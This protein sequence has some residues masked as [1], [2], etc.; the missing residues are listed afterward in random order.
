MPI[1]LRAKLEQELRRMQAL[2]IITP[3]S[4]PTDWV[5]SIV[6]V[7]K[8]N[9]SLRVCLD[10][11]NL[12]K[13]IKRHHHRL[14]TTDEILSRMAGAK[15]FT[16]LDASNA[17]WQ[18]QLDDESSRLLTFN[19]HIG[20]FRFLR[21]PYGI[22]SAS[23][24]CQA[25]IADIISG[26][27][28]TANAQDD[29]IIW[30][31]SKAQLRQRTHNCLQAIRESGLKLRKDKCQ[32]MQ[33]EMTFLGHTISAH[34]IEPDFNKI[35]AI[36]EMPN[37]TNVK[38]L[39]R[40]LGMIT[41][42]GK[43]IP[44]LSDETTPLRTLLEKDII[45]H[46][47]T[48]QTQAVA[49]LKSLITAS[50]VLKYFDPR[51]N[52]RI[53]SDASKKGLGAV[54]EQQHDNLWHPIAFASR[55]LSPAEQNYCPLERETLSIVFACEK[56]HEYV[57]GQHFDVFN[58]HQP[59]KSIF[60]KP[61]GKAPA[62]LQR[63]LLRLQRYDFTMHYQQGKDAYITDALSRAALPDNTPEIPDKELSAFVHSVIN[64]IP[65]SDSRLKQ[66]QIE[67]A[68]DKV[69]TALTNCIQSGWPCN[70]SDVDPTVRPFYNFREELSLNNKLVLKGS[71]IIVPT[72]MRKE[73]LQTLH[74]G[75]PGITKIKLKARSSL[76][77]P[78]IDSQLEDTVNSCSLCQEY[79]N[80][81]QSEPLLHH[82]IPAVPWYKIGTDVF[83]LF[84]RHYLLIVDYTTNYFDISQLP[85]LESTTVIQHTKAIFAKY[86]I[87]KEIMSD[88][89]PEF[90][91]AAY[92]QFCSDWDIIHTTS[93]PRYPQSN[94]LVERTIQTVKRT[95]KKAIRNN[96]DIH[97]ALLSLK[98]TPLQGRPSPAAMFFN[99]TP[100]TLL[101]TITNTTPAHQ[102]K[103]TPSSPLTHNQQPCNLP[104]LPTGASVRLHDGKSWSTRGHITSKVPQPRSYMV[105]TETGHTVRRNRKHLLQAREHSSPAEYD[106]DSS[107][108]SAPTTVAPPDDIQPQ[109]TN[110]DLGTTEPTITEPMPANEDLHTTRKTTSGRTIRKP[111]Y[112]NEF[113][114]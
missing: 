97:L 45:W 59:L 100:R 11:R 109:D 81:Q 68:N 4:E 16:K 21:M 24:I 107:L 26:I 1:P 35:A 25:K 90:A 110:H 74:T 54:L 46:F 2:G 61:L 7:E 53:S 31:S 33:T 17:F 14:P 22:H 85:D 101:P 43:F 63:F 71:R 23:E 38:E 95:L 72:T 52:T 76:Y 5:S 79:R 8:P 28:G 78:G 102:V 94:G 103:A 80:Q 108:V 73:M 114:E 57:Y 51:C 112:L 10:P 56:F 27:D 34:G 19:T 60:S 99:R 3:V 82:D 58:D 29:I 9:G 91:A 49:R 50:P 64:N 41:Y 98:T 86:G 83:H 89:G 111:A 32:F 55:S 84:N 30:G 20:R 75:H 105:L 48:P 66:F 42:L 40:F 37:P 12:N 87:P 15:Y 77:W 70:R 36:L 39:Q 113:T 65:M 13:A 106:S 44:N 104:P 96:E 69:L 47:G 18:V 6:T 88:N 62:R 93:S 92:N 67:T